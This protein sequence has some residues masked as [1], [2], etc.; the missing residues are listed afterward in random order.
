[1]NRIISA[2]LFS[3]AIALTA[4]AADLKEVNETVRVQAASKKLAEQPTAL[5]LYVKGLCCPSCAIGIRKK[6]S[7]LAFVDKK[8]FSKGVDLDAKTQLVLIGLKSGS[9]PDKA[10]LAKAIES[11]GY[12]PVHLYSL[13]NGMLKTTPLVAKK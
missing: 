10:A 11:A 1:M 9:T 4:S 12:D 2:L 13:N 3:F 7:R 5:C 6:V 8:Q